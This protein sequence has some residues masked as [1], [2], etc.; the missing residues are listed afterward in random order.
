MKTMYANRDRIPLHMF[1]IYGSGNIA[2]N[3]LNLLWFS[4]MVK[5]MIA[6][7]QGKGKDG[8]KVKGG[9]KDKKLAVSPS[10]P[11]VAPRE[12]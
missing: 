6:K 7:L 9:R 12:L 8:S 3:G 1:I 2:L 11:V 4:K 10:S 5:Q